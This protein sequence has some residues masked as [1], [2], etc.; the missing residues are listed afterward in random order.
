MNCLNI[1]CGS[2]F[3][4]DWTNIDMSPC[5]VSI[6]KVNIMNG[7]PFPDNSF[8]VVYNSQ[9]LEHIPKENAEVFMKECYRVLKPNGIIRVVVPDLENIV[10]EYMKLLHENIANPNETSEVN[11]DWIMLE[12]YDQTVR[13]YS[14]GQMAEFLSQPTMLNEKYVIDRI[15]YVGRTIRNM[16][17]DNYGKV[18][19]FPH[20]S[21]KLFIKLIKY[22]MR[23]IRVILQPKALKVGRFRL[24]GEIHVWMYDRFSL[25]RLLGRSE[26]V[27]ISQKTPYE[28]DIVGWE[29][30][31]LDVKENV[32]YDP[33][34]LFMEGRK[35]MVSNQN[36]DITI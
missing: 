18:A 33:T 15:G 13:H 4:T 1:G 14:G 5:H 24:S 3:H 17:L 21:C 22:L 30:Y 25:A 6:K 20:L 27:N 2:K 7:L 11:Y 35:G 34:S 23:K 31:E 29:K 19:V 10:N 36:K 12:L 32:V 16:Y 8:D 28:S 9:V 26:F